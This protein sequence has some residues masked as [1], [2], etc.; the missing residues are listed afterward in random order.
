MVA[1]R[2]LLKKKTEMALC[3]QQGCWA[4]AA[5]MFN[6]KKLLFCKKTDFDTP[7]SLPKTKEI[8]N[9]LYRTKKKLLCIFNASFKSLGTPPVVD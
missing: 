9:L 3:H 1:T 6:A 2:S 5:C 8:S 7:W 4:G